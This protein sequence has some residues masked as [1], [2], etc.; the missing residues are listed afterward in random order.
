MMDKEKAP[1]PINSIIKTIN[2]VHQAF[3]KQNKDFNKYFLSLNLDV[4]NFV[5]ILSNLNKKKSTTSKLYESLYKKNETNKYVYEQD[6]QKTFNKL[7]KMKDNKYLP[8]N[9]LEKFKFK[10]ID[11]DK[12][13]KEKKKIMHDDQNLKYIKNKIKVNDNFYYEITLDPG[14]YDPKYN[15]IFKKTPNV[16]IEKEKKKK[17][18]KINNDIDIDM[19]REK[20]KEEK[21]IKYIDNAFN[22]YKKLIIKSRN[23]D[24]KFIT[25]DDID[26]LRKF[27]NNRIVSPN[28][29]KNNKKTKIFS[30]SMINFKPNKILTP[31]FQNIN[32][33]IL[34][35]TQNSSFF[36]H[37]PSVSKKNKIH[38]ADFKT[39]NFQ[40]ESS[41]QNNL[42]EK[43]E[44]NRCESCRNHVR[45]ISFDKM[46]GREKKKRKDLRADYRSSSS[47][48]KPSYEIVSP[49]HIRIRT[50]FEKFQNFKKYA[51]GK[52]IRNYYCFSPSDYFIFDINKKN[53]SIDKNYINNVNRKYNL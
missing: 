42:E 18:T 43:K 47:I 4:L 12:P 29:T 40:F 50:K 48:Y 5:K 32:L 34:N 14:R 30:S 1:D 52:I 27:N 44:L 39:Q 10:F 15:L 46:V 23:K 3:S 19:N 45:I 53:K 28:T 7:K 9:L 36:Q 22:K 51:V 2:P 41:S 31:K 24:N 8:K 11:L 20:E 6:I 33:K 35:K 16:Y 13:K 37:L 38:S 21:D 26:K 17:N 25:I 49:R